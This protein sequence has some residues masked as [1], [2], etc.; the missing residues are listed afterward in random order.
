M[1]Q[2]II[3]ILTARGDPPES[4]LGREAQAWFL[5]QV[6]AHNPA[7]SQAI[8]D[9]PDCKPY[10]VSDL[11]ALPE[12][13]GLGKDS[14]ALRITA[15]SEA[16]EAV[17]TEKLLP[18]LPA[19]LKLWYRVFA[20]RRA[21]T[22][23][24]QHP[25]AVQ[26]SYGE[27]AR[28]ARIS[29][30][31]IHMDFLTPTAFRSDGVDIPLPIPSHVFRGCWQK[32]NAYAPPPLRMDEDLFDFMRDCLLI[33]ALEN[34]NT[35]RLTFSNGKRGGA[36]GFTGSVT[37]SF[38]MDKKRQKWAAEW[39]RWAEMARTLALFSLY[40]GSG[41]HTTIGMGQTVPRIEPR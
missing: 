9:T 25:L 41:H 37:F 14:Y 4:H 35:Q 26:A 33:D 32:W 16:L 27:L 5:N 7:L 18:N 24:D 11:Y 17:L 28:S 2:S 40:C 29:A 19:S 8:H 10:T 38:H 6:Q 30:S 36:T 31:S 22:R 23:A 3:L 1:P 12:S 13:V 34:L 39:D 20:I 15:F 21:V